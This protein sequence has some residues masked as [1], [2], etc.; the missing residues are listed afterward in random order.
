MNE[1]TYPSGTACLFSMTAR[2]VTCPYCFSEN[3]E[4]ISDEQSTWF[5]HNCETLFP[6]QTSVSAAGVDRERPP[7]GG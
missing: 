2:V 7:A 1:P 6:H 3:T 4:V 5:C